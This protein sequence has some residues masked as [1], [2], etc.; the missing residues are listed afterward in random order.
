M[1]SIEKDVS[2]MQ[3]VIKIDR[4]DAIRAGTSQDE[5]NALICRISKLIYEEMRGSK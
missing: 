5:Y 4:D 2:R 1:I 3:L